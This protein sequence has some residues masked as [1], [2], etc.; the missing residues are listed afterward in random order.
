MTAT[1]ACN[2]TISS[3][4]SSFSPSMNEITQPWSIILGGRE[5]QVFSSYASILGGSANVVSGPFTTVMGGHFNT[6]SGRGATC[7]SSN[8]SVVSGNFAVLLSGSN[9]SARGD[10]TVVV[11]PNAHAD[12]HHSA[13]LNFKAGLDGSAEPGVC[14]SQGHGTVNVCVGDD[15]ASGSES[16]LHSIFFN[17]ASLRDL[18]DTA[19][20]EAI[21]VR[22][23]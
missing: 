17:G 21:N 8:R 14:E 10:S 16:P 7:L 9:S 6:A 5:N 20:R 3:V 19:V 2:D 1:S 23:I 11:G 18:I 22:I 12:H 15:T 13:V 4:V